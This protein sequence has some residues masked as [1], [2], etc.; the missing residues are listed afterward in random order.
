M[1]EGVRLLNLMLAV[2]AVAA[3]V[4]AVPALLWRHEQRRAR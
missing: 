2:G 3:V 1:E 4:L